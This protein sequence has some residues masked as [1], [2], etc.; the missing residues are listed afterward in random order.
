MFGGRGVGID[1][2]KF[3]LKRL[4]PPPPPPPPPS[5]LQL[6]NVA[7]HIVKK[8]EMLFVMTLK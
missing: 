6:K 7:K 5:H 2:V 3:G 1:V 4:L 8:L